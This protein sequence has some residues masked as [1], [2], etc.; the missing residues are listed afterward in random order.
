MTSRSTAQT[1]K[2]APS[3]AE[4]G[5][6]STTPLVSTA[7]RSLAI[8]GETGE[9]RRLNG[10]AIPGRFGLAE[11]VSGHHHGAVCSACGLVI[12][13]TSSAR[14]EVALAETARAIAEA[15]GIDVADHRLELVGRCSSC[16]RATG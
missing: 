4:S 11:E 2:T 10:T 15:N 13:A 16:A 12:D 3:D 6:P 9:V 14:F 8:P 1:A 7:S 5:T